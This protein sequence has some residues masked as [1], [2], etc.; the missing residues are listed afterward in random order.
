M[1]TRVNWFGDF[2]IEGGDEWHF[3][4]NGGDAPGKCSLNIVEKEL[5]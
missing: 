2:V 4:E 1:F 5:S 3:R